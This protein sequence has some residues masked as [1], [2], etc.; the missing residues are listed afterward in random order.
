M[1]QVPLAQATK[2]EHDLQRNSWAW[3]ACCRR[4]LATAGT[5]DVLTG[6]I[7]ALL[8]QGLTCQEAA[9]GGV[10]AH[11][12]A[13]DIAARTFGEMAIL[14][15]DITDHLHMVWMDMTDPVGVV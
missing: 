3:G 5:G 2:V 9:F 6:I 1:K 8:A 10:L 14:A 4:A 7:A 12:L 11:A 15:G 13:G